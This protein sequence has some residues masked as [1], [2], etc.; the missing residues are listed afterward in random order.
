MKVLIVLCLAAM[1][2]A[3]EKKSYDKHDGYVSCSSKMKLS[4]KNQ[5]NSEKNI[6]IRFF[7]KIML[8]VETVLI[9]IQFLHILSAFSLNEWKILPCLP[10]LHIFSQEIKII[11]IYNL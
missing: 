5:W 7:S 9:K 6:L 1:A 11:I 3:D 4:P 2:L 10:Y 8:A